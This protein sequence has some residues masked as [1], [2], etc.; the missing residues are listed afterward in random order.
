[1]I[2]ERDKTMN[3]PYQNQNPYSNQDYIARIE[4]AAR[5]GAREGAREA[6]REGAREGAKEGSRESIFR[7]ARR[8]GLG[9]FG[10][11]II[12]LVLLGLLAAGLIYALNRLTDHKVDLGSEGAAESHDL[13]LEDDGILGYTAAD[14][15]EAILERSERE[16]KLVVYTADISDVSTITDTGLVHL[17]FF[18]KTQFITYHG[19]AKYSVDLSR[20]TKRSVEL[21]EKNK[22]VTLYIPHAEMEPINIQSE[23][24]EFGDVQKGFL[25]FGDLKLEP[26][27]MAEVQTTAQEKM[28][29]KLIELDEQA[30]ADEFAKMSVWQDFQPIVN[31]A[32]SGYSLM[33]EFE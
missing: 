6:A 10:R 25:A 20:L 19:T 22:V 17:K 4:Q 29:E 28:K 32:G 8:G 27:E 23:D 31:S 18:T 7:A 26:E 24:I 16:N 11:I 5:D 3:D 1:M 15:Q 12:V 13:I 2:R 14:F 30:T 33:V 9:I 21:D